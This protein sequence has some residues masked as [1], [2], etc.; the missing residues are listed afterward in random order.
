[1]IILRPKHSKAS[2]VSAKI[3]HLASQY[4]LI[5]TDDTMGLILVSDYPQ[6]IK[7]M[8]KLLQLFDTDRKR[9]IQRIE[10][11]QY[12]VKIALPKLKS[13]FDA[14]TDS[15]KDEIKLMED[16]YQNAI[17]IS[18][19]SEDIQKAVNFVK[20]FDLHGEDSAKMDTKIL[21]LQNANVEDIVVTAQ[22]IAKSKDTNS[23]IKSVITSNKELNAIIISSTVN[24]IKELTDLIKKLDIERRQVFVRS[25]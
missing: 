18:A 8:N 9:D 22:E 7:K 17:W 20:A 10:L 6:N 14:T 11:K 24:Q 5:T 4:A 16:E 2:V 23:P 13:I 12:N 1:L 19:N 15:Y 21:F 3:K 25:K